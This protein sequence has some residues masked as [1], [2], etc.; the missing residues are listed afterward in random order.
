MFSLV[1]GTVSVLLGHTG[2]G[3]TELPAKPSPS[4]KSTSPHIC[5]LPGERSG[6]FRDHRGGAGI[7][8]HHSA[9]TIRACATIVGHNTGIPS[10]RL[11][12]V[13]TDGP[14]IRIHSNVIAKFHEI[15]N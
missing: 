4:L 7:P 13:R 11:L 1:S 6:T 15:V 9:V 10:L 5:P 2:W 12:E 8:G 14:I 3:S